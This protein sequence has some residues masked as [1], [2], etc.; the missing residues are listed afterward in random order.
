MRGAGARS[1]PTLIR[2]F[3][4]R[5]RLDFLIVLEPRISGPVADTV[6][7]RIG[8]EFHLRSE[9]IGF[10]GGI[11]LLWNDVGCDVELIHSHK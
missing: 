8:L 5:H 6:I 1:F 4:F 2:D 10:S 11:W 7:R 9:A 3:C